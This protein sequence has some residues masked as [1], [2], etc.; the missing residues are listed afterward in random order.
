MPTYKSFTAAIK[1]LMLP[2]DRAGEAVVNSIKTMINTNSVPGKELSAKWKAR[3]AQNSNTKL[4]E[5]GYLRDA[6]HYAVDK[7]IVEIGY[8]NTTSQHKSD[9]KGQM[10][11]AGMAEVH[12]EGNS[13]GMYNIPK[14]PFLFDNGSWNEKHKQAIQKFIQNYY[15]SKGII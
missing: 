4:L 1:D 14:R 15:K 5:Y 11:Y 8:S 9:G 3:K 10:T 6:T 7:N 13:S 12:N 2:M